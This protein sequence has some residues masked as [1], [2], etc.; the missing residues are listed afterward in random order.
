[1]R[2]TGEGRIRFT[3]RSSAGRT[4]RIALG[5]AP[6]EA[7]DAEAEDLAQVACAARGAEGREESSGR[8]DARRGEAGATGVGVSGVMQLTGHLTITQPKPYIRG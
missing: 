2:A 8:R 5:G 3:R 7:V 4:L 1:M 6:A